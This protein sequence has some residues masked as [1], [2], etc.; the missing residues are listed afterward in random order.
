MKV[1]LVAAIVGAVSMPPLDA[2]AQET[3]LNFEWQL[4]NCLNETNKSDICKAFRNGIRFGRSVGAD[5]GNIL[6]ASVVVPLNNN[7]AWIAELGSDPAITTATVSIRPDTPAA[8]DKF[9][10]VL[11]RSGE[12]QKGS[13]SVELGKY[14]GL[15]AE[16]DRSDFTAEQLTIPLPNES[17]AQAAADA[18]TAAVESLPAD[19]RADSQ[20]EAVMSPSPIVIPYEASTYPRVPMPGAAIP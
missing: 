11:G 15:V 7:D 10:D 13:Y 14:P 2:H 16:L 5:P 9:A 3:Q 17:N 4:A 12:G 19:L 8:E 6:S 20:I 18:I 1:R